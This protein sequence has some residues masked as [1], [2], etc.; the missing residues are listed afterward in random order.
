M[1]YLVSV[2]C[3]FITQVGERDQHSQNNWRSED[4][5]RLQ[6]V[7]FRSKNLRKNVPGGWG[8]QGALPGLDPSPRRGVLPIPTALGSVGWA[9]KPG[10]ERAACGAAG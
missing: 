4:S 1:K 5:S 8:E 7:G 3:E 2:F 6:M 10:N 9:G